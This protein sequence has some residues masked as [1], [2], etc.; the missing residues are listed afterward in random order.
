[1]EISRSAVWVFDLDDTL[2]SE[3]DYQRSGYLHIAH[4]LKNL[5][6]QDILDIIDKADSEGK[7]V[8]Q[9]ICYTLSLPDSV[10]QSL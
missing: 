8:L 2:Y 3:K 9:E 10:K 6:Q 4:Q 7:D 1:M 5:Y